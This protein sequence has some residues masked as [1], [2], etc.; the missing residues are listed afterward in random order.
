MQKVECSSQ[1]QKMFHVSRSTVRPN[2]LID[3]ETETSPNFGSEWREL[4]GYE[5][6][7]GKASTHA[8]GLQFGFYCPADRIR[9][10]CLFR[11]LS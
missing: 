2:K 7:D 4:S 1:R 11:F 3:V 9:T 10:P 5:E 6:G 8:M